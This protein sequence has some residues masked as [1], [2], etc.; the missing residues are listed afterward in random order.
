MD[1]LK[2]VEKIPIKELLRYGPDAVNLM[3]N[4]SKKTPQIQLQGVQNIKNTLIKQDQYVV[5]N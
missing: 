1:L 5:V 2:I 3:E 4:T